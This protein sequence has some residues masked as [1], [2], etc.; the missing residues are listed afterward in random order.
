M[1]PDDQ[2]DEKG[3]VNLPRGP[4]MKSH[5]TQNRLEVLVGE[6]ITEGC[7]LTKG[8]LGFRTWYFNGNKHDC[9]RSKTLRIY[10][11]KHL[12]H[13]ELN[14]VMMNPNIQALISLNTLNNNLGM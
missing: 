8:W 6:A 11:L 5:M 7:Q 1:Q 4:T 12:H 13:P 14:W 2:S 3:T 10:L 9:T